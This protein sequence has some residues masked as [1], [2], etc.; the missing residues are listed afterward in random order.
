MRFRDCFTIDLYARSNRRFGA[1]ALLRKLIFNCG[2][3]VVV[4]YRIATYL[5]K[6]R[7]PRR[8]AALM[9]SLILVRL[10]RVPGVEIRMKDEIGAGILM[11]H[12]HDIVLGVGCRIGRNVTIYNGVTLGAR[13][14][15]T[16][17]ENKEVGGRYPV[18]E[19]G[20][21]I[22]AGAKIIGPVTI[23]ENSI[24]G[25]NSVVNRSF[26]A[27]SVIAG[28]PGRVVGERGGTGTDMS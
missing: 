7:F 19:N 13:T 10:C 1:G 20:V 21:T 6:V 4:Y 17:D 3:R 25:T 16:I 9:G 14:L 11:Y 28:S 23:G 8:L 26:P 22:F 12:P 27:N 18:I 15:K 5:G 2:Y 24:V